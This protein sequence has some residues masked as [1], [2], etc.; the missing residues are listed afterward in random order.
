MKGEKIMPRWKIL[1]PIFVC[2]LLAALFVAVFSPFSVVP[3]RAQDTF[4]TIYLPLV[5]NYQSGWGI[6]DTGDRTVTID[7]NFR[8]EFDNVT[9]ANCNRT[10]AYVQF[11]ETSIHSSFVIQIVID[12]H[13]SY[14]DLDYAFHE[15]YIDAD[16]H[17]NYAMYCSYTVMQTANSQERPKMIL[18]PIVRKEPLSVVGYTVTWASKI[19]IDVPVIHFYGITKDTPDCYGLDNIFLNTE[20]TPHSY[21]WFKKK[22]VILVHKGITE[23]TVE[24]SRIFWMFSNGST[25]PAYH[26]LQ[27]NQLQGGIYPPQ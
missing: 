23:T 27:C 9:L 5:S 6:R 12:D 1:S 3:A 22:D 11:K 4:K 10:M 7:D 8:I 13:K 19:G 26:K 14:I 2:A 18:L 24:L 25:N 17:L 20:T 15:I 16:N 21:Y